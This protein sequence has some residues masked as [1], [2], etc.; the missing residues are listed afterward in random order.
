MILYNQM[1]LI[2]ILFSRRSA[3]YEV[4]L[5]FGGLCMWETQVEI[6]H[7]RLSSKLMIFQSHT[8]PPLPV[9]KFS[10]KKIVLCILLKVGLLLRI[11][12][13]AQNWLL[14]WKLSCKKIYRWNF[15]LRLNSAFFWIKKSMNFCQFLTIKWM[16]LL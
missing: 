14:L 7:K 6:I 2:R 11:V 16:E 12:S 4:N 15:Y 13:H 8:P 3:E 10:F 1:F 9:I 5:D